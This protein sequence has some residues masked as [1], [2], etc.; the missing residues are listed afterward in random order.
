MHLLL[1][2][3]APFPFKHVSVSAFSLLKLLL[4]MTPPSHHRTPTIH[5]VI[6][7]SA[8][9]SPPVSG[10]NG[11]IYIAFAADKGLTPQPPPGGL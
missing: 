8:V 6:R 7:L 4:C 9:S 3:L 1:Y 5:R 2:H 11:G 10:L